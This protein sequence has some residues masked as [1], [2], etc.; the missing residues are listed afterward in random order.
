MTLQQLIAERNLSPDGVETVETQMDCEMTLLGTVPDGLHKSE[1][2]QSENSWG[3]GIWAAGSSIL[4]S[5]RVDELKAEILQ[6]DLRQ[7]ARWQLDNPN[8]KHQEAE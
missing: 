8:C 1:I 3:I 7:D 5:D 2:W 4:D 6:E